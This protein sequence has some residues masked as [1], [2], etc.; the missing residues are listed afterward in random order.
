MI[1]LV[2]K[3]IDLFDNDIYKIISVE[4]SL[5]MLNS[6]SVIGFDTETTGLDAHSNKI[7][8]LQLGNSDFQ[9]DIDINTIDINLYK[10]ILEDENI[11]KV[12]ANLKFDYQFCLSNNIVCKNLYDVLLS[13]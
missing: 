1:Y 12:G 11:I 4:E 6:L 7:I 2:T 3:Q 8:I 5:N 9:I 10:H 13:E